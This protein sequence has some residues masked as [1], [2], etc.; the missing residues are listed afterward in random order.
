M[1]EKFRLS[2]LGYGNMGQAIVGGLIKKGII[3]PDRIA[4]YDPE[5]EK[6]KTAKEMGINVVSSPDFLLNESKILL[7]AVKPQVLRDALYPL[8]NKVDESIVLVSIVAGVPIEFYKRFFGISTLKI[9]RTMPNT[10]ALVGCGITGICLSSECSDNEVKVAEVIFSAVGEVVFVAE[11]QI[12][13][14]TAISGSGPAYF[15]YL[16]E[17]L[18]RAGE[19]LGL[20]RE[21]AFKLAVNTLYGAG[22]LAKNSG[23]SPET[24]RMKVTS[25]GGTTERAINCFGSR[26]F[27]DIVKEAVTSAYHRAKELGEQ[28]LLE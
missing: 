17:G 19:A 26:D 21:I 8:K 16:C 3:T 5:E 2:V 25:K 10:P 9:I 18:I 24:L 11:P 6:Q 28:N 13:I 4:V 12:D 15:F 22:V 14:I 20:S 27:W 1:E 23:E 7:I